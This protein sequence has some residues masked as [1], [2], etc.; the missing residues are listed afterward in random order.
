MSNDLLVT[1]L[2][3]RTNSIVEFW[4]LCLGVLAHSSKEF[5]NC[6]FTVVLI[7]KMCHVFGNIPENPHN[8]AKCL[9]LP[10]SQRGHKIFSGNEGVKVRT[11]PLHPPT[12]SFGEFMPVLREQFM[13]LVKDIGGAG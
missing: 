11:L 4:G 5:L 2:G 7:G 13:Y 10:G 8:L 6:P 1:E 9:A 12:V 3:G